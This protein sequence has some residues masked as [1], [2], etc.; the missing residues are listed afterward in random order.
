[1][2]AKKQKKQKG[3]EPEAM[4]PSI[5]EVAEPTPFTNRQRVAYSLRTLVAEVHDL[6]PGV[7][8]EFANYDGRNTALAAVF[9]LTVLDDD[10]NMNLTEVLRL[11]VTDPRVADVVAEDGAVAVTLHSNP[12]T[13]DDR[14]RFGLADAY[15]VLVGESDSEVV[16]WEDDP[17]SDTALP[18]DEEGSQ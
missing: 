18:L 1:M 10:D 9:D 15:E 7:P 16:E 17:L 4:D 14:G 3:N 12:R 11:T 8:V 5:R 13:Q 2:A 6:F